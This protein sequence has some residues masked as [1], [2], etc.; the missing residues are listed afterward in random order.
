MRRG[1]GGCPRRTKAR[2]APGFN[3]T[4]AASAVMYVTP[5]SG[6]DLQNGDQQPSSQAFSGLGCRDSA[7]QGRQEGISK[8][9]YLV[10]VH[11]QRG[12][13]CSPSWIG[14]P[15]AWEALRPGA[16]Q[17][18]PPAFQPSNLGQQKISACKALRMLSEP[19]K[20]WFLCQFSSAL[21]AFRKSSFSS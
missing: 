12:H 20:C 11:K 15:A 9:G 13:F 7:R 14:S 10:W 4:S 21:L 1:G 6:P 18:R 17:P 2:A 19:R 5:L 8:L 3:P 16:L